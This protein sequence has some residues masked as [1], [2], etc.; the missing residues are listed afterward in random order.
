[1][2]KYGWVYVGRTAC[3][4][5]TVKPDPAMLTP[6]SLLLFKI[7]RRWGHI[8]AHAF[9]WYK[10]ELGWLVDMENLDIYI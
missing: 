10:D 7:S 2:K 5:N 1:M 4:I 3:L 8:F 6:L 9:C